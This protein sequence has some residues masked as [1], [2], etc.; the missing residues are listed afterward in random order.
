MEIVYFA[1]AFVLLTALI[2]GVL[3]Y[4]YRNKAATEAGGKVA[5]ERYRNNE[6]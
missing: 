5:Q 4:H 6:T 2:Y 1:G 3:S